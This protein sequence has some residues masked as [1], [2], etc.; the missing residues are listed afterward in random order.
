MVV[1][2]AI[3]LN[4]YVQSRTLYTLGN[5]QNYTNTHTHK[6]VPLIREIKTGTNW[7]G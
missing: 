7:C 6:R 1:L 2:P 4:K 5:Y 3:P